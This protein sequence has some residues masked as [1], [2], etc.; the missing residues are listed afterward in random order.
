MDGPV[1][2]FPQMGD[3]M[4]SAS[5]SA[6]QKTFSVNS[7]CGVWRRTG[8]VLGLTSALIGMSGCATVLDGHPRPVI[9]PAA[10]IDKIT[11]QID[12][13]KISACLET[14]NLACRN[15]IVG[16]RMYAADLRFT[17]FEER[18]FK[19]GRQALFGGS[20]AALTLSAAATASTGGAARVLSAMNTLL[21]GSRESYEKDLLAERTAIAIHTSMRTKRAQVG[22]RLRAGLRHS[23]EDY[24]LAMALS[25]LSEYVHAG[26]VLSA[27]IG[28]T[29]TVGNE[30]RRGQEDFQRSEAIATDF[31]KRDALSKEIELMLCSGKAGCSPNEINKQLVEKIPKC[32]LENKIHLE[33]G[34]AFL[35]TSGS[36]QYSISDRQKVLACLQS[37]N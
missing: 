29:E 27:L 34:P 35:L 18:L 19:E 3:I 12:A 26:T 22:L 17:E 33:S 5:S 6:S 14:P 28:I 9:D 13:G 1:S 16:G 23:V 36:P 31:A 8:W 11:S 4:N 30:A 15:R 10:D 24:P 32:L 2:E 7:V 37:K 20:V 21:L 25:D